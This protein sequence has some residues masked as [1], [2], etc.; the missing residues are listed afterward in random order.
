M[1]HNQS[2]PDH[3]QEIDLVIAELRK[4]TGK[5]VTPEWAAKTRDL[6]LSRPG[7]N[8]RTAYL[9]RVLTTDPDPA[10]F[11]PTTTPPPVSLALRR[12]ED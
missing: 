11:L 12:P 9:R 1:T 3:D 10:R 4:R 2:K 5:L 6:I 7:V 8:N